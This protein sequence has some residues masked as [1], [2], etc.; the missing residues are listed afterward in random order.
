MASGDQLS[1][2]LTKLRCH[3]EEASKTGATTLAWERMQH[4]LEDAKL[5]W[6]AH[7]LPEFVAISSFNRTFAT[8][9]CMH[10]G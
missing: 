2:C 4:D 6:Y 1:A 7:A 8:N 9:V 3:L 5:A 10:M